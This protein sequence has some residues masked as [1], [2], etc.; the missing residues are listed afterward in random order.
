LEINLEFYR[1]NDQLSDE[2][3]F[4]SLTSVLDKMA[5]LS[6]VKMKLV[7]LLLKDES[8]V[9]AIEYSLIAALIAVAAIGSF[10]LIGTSL[11]TTFSTVASNL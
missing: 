1:L 7:A 3:N 10:S 9:T 6:E 11:S 8:G 5:Y 4:S 2:I